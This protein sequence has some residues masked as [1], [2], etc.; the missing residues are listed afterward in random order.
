MP[1]TPT[2][3]L[4]MPVY[5]GEA[6][7]ADAIESVLAQT[8]DDWELIVIDDGSNDGTAAVVEGFLPHDAI[9]FYSQDN[10]GVTATTNRG[11]E[12]AR[13]EFLGIHPQDDVSY[14][15]RLERQVAV[16]E[17]YPDVG[18]VYS[19]AQ[20]VDLDGEETM[21]WGGWH[22]EGRVPG[23]ELFRQ[24]YVDGMCIASPSVLFRRD[25]LRG[26]AEPWGDP[27][28]RI[29]SDWEHW[30][31]AAQYYD[32]YEMAAP[33]IEMLRDEAHGNLASRRREVFAEERIVIRRVRSKH[34]DGTPPVTRRMF[35]KAMSN[36]HL[37]ALRYHLYE[38]RALAAG[39]AS[40]LGAFL[41]NPVNADLYREFGSMVR[42]LR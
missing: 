1:G 22:G 12:L 7:V 23:A 5:D 2:V 28:L 16:F 42:T 32:A 26:R 25:H 38:E 39:L 29:V 24:L 33:T 37:R 9:R 11:I 30:L 8:Y 14:P 40:A 10:R 27:S 21:V 19:P 36:H 34:A 17:E 6:F 13:G 35:A 31:D 15:D 4:I 18:L 3:S 41:Y 20:F